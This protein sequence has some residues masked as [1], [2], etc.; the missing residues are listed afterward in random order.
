MFVP[1][2][3]AVEEMREPPKR[4][5]LRVPTFDANLSARRYNFSVKAETES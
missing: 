4:V 1:E 2:R 3:T 5:P